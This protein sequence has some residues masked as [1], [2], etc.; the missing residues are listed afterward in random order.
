MRATFDHLLYMYQDFA[1][2]LLSLIIILIIGMPKYYLR[3]AEKVPIL[4]NVLRGAIIP[5]ATSNYSSE[6][7]E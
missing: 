7:Q 6:Q 1:F 4:E 2:F 5:S 3:T